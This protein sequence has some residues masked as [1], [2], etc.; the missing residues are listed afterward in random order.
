MMNYFWQLIF[1]YLLFEYFDNHEWYAHSPLVWALRLDF[2]WI[3]FVKIVHSLSSFVLFLFV[4][5][6][7]QKSF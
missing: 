5:F 6:I 7:P 4:L 1:V 3:N 2:N